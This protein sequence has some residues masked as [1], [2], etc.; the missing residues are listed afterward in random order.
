MIS[1]DK[2]RLTGNHSPR[3]NVALTRALAQHNGA[4]Q[5]WHDLCLKFVRSML[6][7]PAGAGTA[8]A[9]WHAAG[10]VDQHG[11]YSPP[12]GVPVF[13]GGGQGHVALADGHGNVWTT[14]FDRV[15]KV[16]L[17]PIGDITKGWGKPY[18]GWTSTLNGV[19]VYA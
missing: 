11:W 7:V 13:W 3:A 1:R 19:Q 15:G 14:D 5:D 17:V 12:A 16:D 4:T 9:A 2:L 8:L 18:L 10:G 6:G